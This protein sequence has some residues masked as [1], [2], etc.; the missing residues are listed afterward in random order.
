MIVVI[1]KSLMDNHQA[2]LATQ[3]DNNKYLIA[4]DNVNDLINTVSYLN[5]Y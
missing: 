2:E 3:L 5:N 4:I 1:N